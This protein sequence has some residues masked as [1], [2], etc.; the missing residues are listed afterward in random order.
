MPLFENARQLIRANL[1]EIM[2]A[3]RPK[4]VEIG[5]L[6]DEQLDQINAFRET[7]ELPPIIARVMFIGRHIHRSRIVENGYT[8]DDVIDQ[9]ESSMQS[10]AVVRVTE[11]RTALE[12]P[13][14]RM[15]RYGNSVCD[16]AVLECTAYHPWPELFSVIPIG[17]QK[18][19]KSSKGHPPG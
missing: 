9:I 7:H 19:P 11:I 13:T 10:C 6:S 1:E 4:R 18:R 12:N 14:R 8:I 16:R 15:D 3:R 2:S 17:D 5:D